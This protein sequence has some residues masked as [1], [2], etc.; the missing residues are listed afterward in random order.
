MLVALRHGR[1][2]PEVA[3]EERAA[4]YRAVTRELNSFEPLLIELGPP[5]VKGEAL[6]LPASPTSGLEELRQRVRAGIEIGLGRPAPVAAEQAAGF[7][8]HASIAYARA[9]ADETPYATALGAVAP[10]T[11]RVLITEIAFI[12][13][14][15]ILEPEWPYRWDELARVQLQAGQFDTTTSQRL[16]PSRISPV[17]AACGPQQPNGRCRTGAR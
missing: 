6:V 14:A 2:R 13:Q 12:Q 10:A 17:S 9:D 3:P 8:P 11:M 4:V 5:V 15:R 1:V 7:R 16:P